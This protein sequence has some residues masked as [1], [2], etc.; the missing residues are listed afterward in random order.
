MAS[1]RISVSDGWIHVKTSHTVSNIESNSG[2]EFTIFAN[3]QN[4]EGFNYMIDN[5]TVKKRG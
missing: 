5:V 2:A 4:G 1:K 3:P